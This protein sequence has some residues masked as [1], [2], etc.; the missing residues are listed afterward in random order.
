MAR[1]E[2]RASELRILQAQAMRAIALL[3]AGKTS[4]AAALAEETIAGL[5]RTCGRD[6]PTLDTPSL[7]KTLREPERGRALARMLWVTSTVDEMCGRAEEARRGCLR[8]MELYAR[9]RLESEELDM[10]AARDLGSAS[11]RLGATKPR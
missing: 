5:T 9:L 6:W 8:A 7:L 11:A 3:E 4:E 2:S 10:R 1:D